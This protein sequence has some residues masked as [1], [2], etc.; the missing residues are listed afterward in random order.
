[1]IARLWHGWTTPDDADR[2]EA[3]IR[4]TI[5]PG[6]RARGIAGLTGLELLRRAHDTEVEFVTLMR[7][8]SWAAVEAFA[9]PDRE[10]SV[11]PPAARE[12]LARFDDRAVHYDV[13]AGDPAA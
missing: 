2:Y 10:R 4:S 12:I 13:R 3:L 5:F 11:V 6:I 9:G 8:E 1:M 7:F